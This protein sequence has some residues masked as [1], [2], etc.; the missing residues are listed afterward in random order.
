MRAVY[1]GALTRRKGVH[2]LLQA[3]NKLSLPHAQLTLVGTICEDIKPS[4][5][6]F[7]GPSINVTGFLSCVDEVFCQS[8][9]HIFPSECEGSP[10]SVPLSLCVGL[11]QITTFQSGDVILNEV[12]GLIVPPNDAVALAR[13]RFDVST[14][15]RGE[16]SSMVARLASGR[17][18]NLPGNTLAS[19]WPRAYDL[20]LRQ[21]S[22]P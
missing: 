6:Q 17:K 2:V 4:L 8:D 1:C 18:P 9:L 13:C 22:T 12:N 21:R 10:K 15:R 16:S 11:P 7:E 14:S 5:V 20:V 19:G 3:W